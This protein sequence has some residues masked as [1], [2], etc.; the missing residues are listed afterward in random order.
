MSHE[1]DEYAVFVECSSAMHDRLCGYV[2]IAFPLAEV[3]ETLAAR[4]R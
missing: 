3:E 1:N 2:I 4:E